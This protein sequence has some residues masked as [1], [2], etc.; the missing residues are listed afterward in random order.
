MQAKDSFVVSI[1]RGMIISGILIYILPLV[2]SPKTIWLTM[3]MTE[4]IVGIY[5]LIISAILIKSSIDNEEYSI[6]LIL[7]PFAI[8]GLILMLGI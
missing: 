3:P 6:Q 7:F 2:I 8:S 1:L 4:A 5:V